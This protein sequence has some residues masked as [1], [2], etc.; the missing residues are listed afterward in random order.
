MF[1]HL[2]AS[3]FLPLPPLRSLKLGALASPLPYCPLRSFFPLASA[4]LK[5]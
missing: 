1:L 4:S 2:A 3:T 5:D